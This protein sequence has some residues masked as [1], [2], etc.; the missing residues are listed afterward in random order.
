MNISEYSKQLSKKASKYASEQAGRPEHMKMQ[1]DKT[2]RHTFKTHFIPQDLFQLSLLGCHWLAI[3]EQA[4]IIFPQATHAHITLQVLEFGAFLVIGWFCSLDRE[5]W[6]KRNSSLETFL[7]RTLWRSVKPSPTTFLTV[8][9]DSSKQMLSMDL[10][11][12]ANLCTT[13]NTRAAV[14]TTLDCIT[15]RTMGGFRWHY[16][17]VIFCVLVVECHVAKQWK[18]GQ[19]SHSFRLTPYTCYWNKNFSPTPHITQ[20]LWPLLYYQWP[21]RLLWPLFSSRWAEPHNFP[22]WKPS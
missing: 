11:K 18:A 19:T 20:P 10:L 7:N 2:R 17:T 3:Y 9:T 5:R 8:G 1:T 6:K 22:I 12:V 21:S 13:P 16:V 15:C 14:Y 4:H